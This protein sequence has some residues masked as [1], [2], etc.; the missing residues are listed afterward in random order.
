MVESTGF[1]WPPFNYCW[2]LLLCIR[3]ARS[4]VIFDDLSVASFIHQHTQHARKHCF[5][6]Q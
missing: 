4:D 6:S 5:Y 3:C 2:R 1:A